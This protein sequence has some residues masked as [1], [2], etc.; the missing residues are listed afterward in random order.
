[1]DPK[2][3]FDFCS[4]KKAKPNNWTNQ[5]VDPDPQ[6][7]KPRIRI[8]LIFQTLD[9]DLQEIDAVPNAASAVANC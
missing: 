3:F 9:P 5:A 4:R 8:L 2:F 6:F 1:V 7:F